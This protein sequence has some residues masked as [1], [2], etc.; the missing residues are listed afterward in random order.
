MLDEVIEENLID[1]ANGIG[2]YCTEETDCENYNCLAGEFIENEHGDLDFQLTGKKT[3]QLNDIYHY[4]TSNDHCTSGLCDTVNTVCIGKAGGETCSDAKE[5]VS[6]Q[7][8]ILGSNTEGT[9]A[10]SGLFSYCLSGEDCTEG[11]CIESVESLIINPET[12]LD[13]SNKYCSKNKYLE[14]CSINSDCNS[15]VCISNICLA[16]TVGL[17]CSE[18]YECYSNNCD[19]RFCL[20]ADYKCSEAADCETLPCYNNYCEMYPLVRL[21]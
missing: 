12:Q 1:E 7:C 17:P 19:G 8:D 15:G 11:N 5:C 4:C 3:C 6:Y 20:S 14:E 9:C 21:L 13:L 16:K 2:E 18:S 10:F